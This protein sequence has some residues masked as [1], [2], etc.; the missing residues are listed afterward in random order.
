MKLSGERFNMAMYASMNLYVSN[1]TMHMIHD[2]SITKISQLPKSMS[3]ICLIVFFLYPVEVDQNDD[4]QACH[5]L[6]K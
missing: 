3:V 6:L 1:V 5:Q 4:K 2:S